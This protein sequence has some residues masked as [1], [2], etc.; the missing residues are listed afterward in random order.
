MIDEKSN[1]GSLL[2]EHFMMKL[3]LVRLYLI[4]QLR[5]RDLLQFIVLCFDELI[6]I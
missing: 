1:L 6:F 3:N 4:G 5:A 2:N